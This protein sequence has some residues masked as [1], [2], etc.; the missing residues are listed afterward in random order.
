MLADREG[1]EREIAA[2]LEHIVAEHAPDRTQI[3]RLSDDR[4]EPTA[5]HRGIFS[6]WPEDRA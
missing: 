6:W 4:Y 1:H 2:T 5:I 3:G